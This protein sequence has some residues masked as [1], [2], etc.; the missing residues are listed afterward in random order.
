MRIEQ[1][2][3]V[4]TGIEITGS[5]TEPVGR[6]AFL[7]RCEATER[8]KALMLLANDLEQELKKAP[9]SVVVVRSMDWFLARRENVARP[10][11][12]VEG[13]V[14][15]TARR[16]VP[17]VAASSGKEIGDICGSSKKAVEDD[18][19]RLLAGLDRDAAAAGLA[20]LVLAAAS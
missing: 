15:G 7:H 14:L 3:P 13:M 1:G 17:T 5:A 10:R 12:Q 11:L 9:P 2:N 6:L 8:A 16:C 20:A 19:A 18:A 4:V